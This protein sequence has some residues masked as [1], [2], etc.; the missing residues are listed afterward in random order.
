MRRKSAWLVASVIVPFGIALGAETGTLSSVVFSNY[1]PLSSNA[2]LARRMLSPLTAAQIPGL[3]AQSGKR[4]NDQPV[5]LVEE[6]FA[7]YVPAQKPAG[8]YALLVFVP[9][10]NDARLPDG[11]GPVLDQY[12][13]I[14][15]SAARSGN[16]ANVLGRREPL[17]L[18]AEQNVARRYAVNQARV[19]IAGFSGGSRVAMRLALA[20]PDVLRGA[21]LNAGSDPIGSR[22]IPLPAADLFRQFQ[23]STHI[24][25]V[26]GERDSFR[27][28]M[29]MASM[30]SMRDWCVSNVEDHISAF[31]DHDVV[32]SV[33]LSRALDT[34]LNP[35]PS[36]PARL[37][38]C[39]S[40]IEAELDTKLQQVE[41]LIQ[42]GERDSARDLLKEID[43]R[44][45]GMAAPRSVELAAKLKQ[46]G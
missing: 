20:Y 9:P 8:G 21:I 43:A 25:F 14:F 16:D 10:W 7:V 37:A 42:A 36:D 12:G 13:V 4:L 3:L 1:T 18:L 34:L 33:A 15:V 40:A 28:A 44:F 45:G 5:N 17:A 32:D 11:W 27:L 6:K 46:K 29:D 26:T 41:S 23:E 38:G 22:V 2:E 19:L 30:H 24:V 35:A 31:V 39:R